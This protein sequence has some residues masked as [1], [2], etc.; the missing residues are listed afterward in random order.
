MEVVMAASTLAAKPVVQVISR[1]LFSGMIL[2]AVGIFVATTQAVAQQPQSTADGRVIVIGESSVSVPP[3][4]ARIMSGV[5]TRAGTLKEAI[6]MNSKLMD[7]IIAAL[8]NSGIAQNDVQTSQFSAQP[9]FAPQEP[10]A[11]PKLSGFSVSNQVIVIIRQIRR[12]GEILD[13]MVTAGATDIGNIAFLLSDPSK[14]LDRAR[15]AAV[16]DAR[17]KAELYARAS[18]ISLGR[19]TWITE[20]LRYAPPNLTEALL[21]PAA[22]M[23]SVPIAGGDDTLQVRITV[24]FEIS[25]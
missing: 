20:D 17:R 25:R 12:V 1:P 3:D 14:A 8:L 6:D 24:G 18:G 7:A 16:S 13:H 5:T 23:A 2:L 21:A 9:V 22:R 15:E 19:I 4:Y 10:R 11:E